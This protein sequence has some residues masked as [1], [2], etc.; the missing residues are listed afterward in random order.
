MLHVKVIEQQDSQD[1][2]KHV[3]A[4]QSKICERLPPENLSSL[5]LMMS[6]V[7]DLVIEGSS[8]LFSSQ[9][10]KGNYFQIPCDGAACVRGSKVDTIGMCPFAHQV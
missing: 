3:A 6:T 1:W 2:E 10:L 7:K 9:V 4:I 5:V 8:L